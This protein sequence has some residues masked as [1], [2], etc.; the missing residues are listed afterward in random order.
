VAELCNKLSNARV[1]YRLPT[2]AEWEK[3]A[4]GGLAGKHYAWGD[5]LPTPDRCDFNRFDEF[6]IKPCRA[7]PPNGYGL[8]AM[9]GSVWEWTLDEY[10]ALGYAGAP[11]PTRPSVSYAGKG[12]GKRIVDLPQRVL[13]GGSWADGAEACT[14]SFR[15]SRG[16]VSWR[17]AAWGAKLAPNI[18][19]RIARVGLAP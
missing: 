6:S 4:R 8:Y 13:R 7:L 19:F 2:E 11:A 10:D 9:C 15:M 18:G 12:P 16:S 3:A 14:V 5:D 17:D 1:T